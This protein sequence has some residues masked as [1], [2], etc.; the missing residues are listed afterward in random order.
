MY[1]SH[2]LNKLSSTTI[3]GK[4][5]LDIWSSET[6]QDFSLLWVFECLAYF[7]I[8]NDKLNLQAKKFVF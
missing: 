3:G 1:A 8:K 7:N 4:T 5:L 6:A 2:L